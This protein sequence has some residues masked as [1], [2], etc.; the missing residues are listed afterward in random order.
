[1]I[2]SKGCYTYLWSG[3]TDYCRKH[4]FI[5]LFTDSFFKLQPNNL[6]K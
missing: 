2:A 4:A 6:L 1:M 3:L 5:T